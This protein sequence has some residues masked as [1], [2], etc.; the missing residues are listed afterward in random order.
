MKRILLALSAIVL[1]HLVNAQNAI[2]NPG[3]ELWTNH[4]SYDDPNSWGTINSLTAILGVKTV[5]KATGVDVHSGTYAIKLQSKTV[6]IQGVAPG[7]AATGT[8]NQNT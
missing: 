1:F 8:I 3:F 4:G 6:P 2:P 7:I 5:T